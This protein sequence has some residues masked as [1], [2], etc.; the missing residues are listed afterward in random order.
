MGFG[1]TMG[2]FPRWLM[3][4]MKCE[5]H[6]GYDWI[7]LREVVQCEWMGR[8]ALFGQFGHFGDV[9]RRGQHISREV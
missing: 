5:R 2:T 6:G 9:S 8:L 3:D 7:G 4:N 1:V